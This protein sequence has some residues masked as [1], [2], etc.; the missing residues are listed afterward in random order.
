VIDFNVADPRPRAA[1]PGP[2]A[3]VKLRAPMPVRPTPAI[4]MQEPSPM[5]VFFFGTLQM[6]DDGFV[7]T[8]TAY[9]IDPAE[10][11]ALFGAVQAAVCDISPDLCRL[12]IDP[13]HH[14][15]VWLRTT[16]HGDERAAFISAPAGYTACRAQIDWSGVSMPAHA[17]FS[18]VLERSAA[19]DGVAVD[20]R[21]LQG[22]RAVNWIKADILL[23]FVRTDRLASYNCWPDGAAAWNC[24]SRFC[25]G[26][27]PEGRLEMSTVAPALRTLRNLNAVPPR[28][29]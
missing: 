26:I 4:A 17:T 19:G 20:A 9:E 13:E 18:A 21:V 15:P 8:R 10:G 16:A 5:P 7:F 22:H 11:S 3:S 1:F 6:T 29:N 12:A 27:H 2:G 24:A 28:Q 14:A 25:A 23:S